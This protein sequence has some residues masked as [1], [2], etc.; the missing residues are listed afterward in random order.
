MRGILAERFD[1]RDKGCLFCDNNIETT[2]HLFLECNFIRSL[3]FT[4]RWGLKYD[5]LAASIS[6]PVG[7]EDLLEVILD[8]PNSIVGG[9]VEKDHFT[10]ILACVLYTTWFSRNERLYEGRKSLHQV[11]KSLEQ[12]VEEFKEL[13]ISKEAVP[14]VCREK[15]SWTPPPPDFLKINVDAAVGNTATASAMVVRNYAGN[16]VF[17][18]S[19]ISEPFEPVLADLRLSL[20]LSIMFGGSQGMIFS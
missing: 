8:P 7:I 19:C 18:A 13:L 9:L 10:L 11:L 2:R 3:A 5:V 4:S 16:L 12:N 15:V 20:G 1:L 14:G 6:H 17:L